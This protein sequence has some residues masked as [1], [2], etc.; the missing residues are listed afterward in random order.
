MS[1][2]SL[3]IVVPVYNSQ[4]SLEPLHRRIVASQEAAGRS[5]EIILVD[6]GS[7]DDSWAAIKKLAEQDDRVRGIRLCRNFGQHN[8]LLCGIRAAQYELIATIDDDLQ[9]PPEEIERM[10]AKLN[11]GYDVVYGVPEQEQ[12]GFLRDIAS[13]I[14]KV[15]IQM[16]M[17]VKA[18]RQVSAFRLFRT[19]IRETFRDF[20]SPTMSVDVLLFWGTG[21]FAAIPV[22][23]D[24][25]T[26]GK[27]NY[28]FFK[29]LSHASNMM[30]GFSILP[31]RLA[32]WIG[33]LFTL[34]GF[35]SLA[36][37]VLRF[38][39]QGSSVSGFTFLASIISIF[40]G[41]MMFAL[42]IIGE[43]LAQVHLRVMGRPV[44]SE[45]ERTEATHH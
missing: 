15:S 32:S 39:V 8:A 27:S 16:S 23:H 14:T 45:L 42:G 43:Y 36:F 38:V 20:H 18:V 25:R 26:I 7:H 21:R 19:K 35:A 40:C 31:L 17:G 24:A 3:S 29:L 28:S 11:E 1:R 30:T 12:H 4:K 5:F 2:Q 22:K 44:Y 34:F 6:D 37:V 41:A 10:I 13:Y 9:N 33:F